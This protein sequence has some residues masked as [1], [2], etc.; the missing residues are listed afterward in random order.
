[1]DEFFM[2]LLSMEKITQKPAGREH[3]SRGFLDDG[4]SRADEDGG[5]AQQ[6]RSLR[7]LCT[8]Q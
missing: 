6:I 2:P 8:H 5:I 1:M 4:E 7:S 3:S